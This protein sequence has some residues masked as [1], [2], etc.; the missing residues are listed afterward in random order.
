MKQRN[1]DSNGQYWPVITNHNASLKTVKIP[2]FQSE[3]VETFKVQTFKPRR[4]HKIRSL[5][6]RKF[7]LWWVHKTSARRAHSS[8]LLISFNFFES[9]AIICLCRFSGMFLGKWRAI[10]DMK[11]WDTRVSC[12]T[13]RVMSLFFGVSVS[14]FLSCSLPLSLPCRNTPIRGPSLIMMTSPSTWN[15]FPCQAYF[16]NT[17]QSAAALVV[18][19]LF[20]GKEC[21]RLPKKQA[22]TYER[23][24]VM[25]FRGWQIVHHPYKLLIIKYHFTLYD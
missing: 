5:W 12:I 7:C 6:Q 25:V 14:F 23:P 17:E 21:Q 22:I 8:S 24:P 20:A 15:L 1:S 3:T 2:Y 11:Q 4:P 18:R 9:I 16:W 19:Y 10:T 13:M